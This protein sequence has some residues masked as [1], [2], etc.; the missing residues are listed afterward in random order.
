MKKRK[1]LIKTLLDEHPRYKD[2][3]IPREIMVCSSAV[4]RLS[5]SMGILV[6]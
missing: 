6:L 5:A 1:Y 2:M 4:S 3:E